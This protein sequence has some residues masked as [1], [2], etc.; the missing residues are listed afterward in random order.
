MI[1]F[2]GLVCSECPA[3][4]ATK[5][6]D[7]NKRKE[8]A[9]Q[10]SIQFNADIKPEDINCQGCVSGNEILFSHPRV[11]EIRMCGQ[12]KGIINCAY[13]DDY[14]CDRLSAFFSSVPDAKIILDN[15]R[16]KL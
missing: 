11:C 16:K 13:C 3:F 2:C 4:I 9:K 6:D 14:A 15:I 8:T 7:D 5:A 10:W 1:A 12:E